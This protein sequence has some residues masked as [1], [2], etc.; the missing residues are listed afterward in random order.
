[1]SKPRLFYIDN[2]RIFLISLVVLLH[3]NITYGAPGDWY[4]N[5]SEAG[6]PEI[7]LQAMFNITNQAFFMGMFFFISAYFTAASL[8]R[9]T[10]GKFLKDRLIRLGIPL[11]VFYF[12]LNP[13]TNFIHYYFIKHEAVTFTGFLTNPR[14][15]GF[16]PMWF[17]ETLLIF[18]LI[19]LLIKRLKWKIRM[20]FPGTKVI[21]IAAVLIGLAQ[22]I[23]RIWL[24]VGWSLPHTGLQFP[25]FV[26]YIF[27]LIFGVVAYNNNWL[28]TISFKSA[29]RWFVFAQ[30]MILTVLPAMLYVGGK[31]SGIEAFVGGGTWQSFAWAIWEQLVGFAMIMGLLGLA[32]KYRNHQGYLARQLSD[33]AYG[34]YVIHPPVIVGISA[35]F[36]AWP[37][38]Q[39]V[40]FIVLAPLALF[41]CFLLA[42]L[43]KQIPGVKKVV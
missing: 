13:L 9:K 43:I 27:M 20:N 2:L 3:L 16:G 41:A 32:K 7:I 26:Q 1:M 37:I 18:T 15:W 22:Y 33:S 12:V 23:I 8:Q 25:F 36:V 34:V 39:L 10:T 14:A 40:K 38:N 5:E 42:W 19:Y 29:L 30:I 24:P 17:V 35:L 6:M 31:E 4:Y 21:V 28:E 11:L